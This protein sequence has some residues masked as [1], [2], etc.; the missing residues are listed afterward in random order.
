MG[1]ST[2]HDRL[3]YKERYV[4]ARS[5]P[6]ISVF[7]REYHDSP[8]GG[9]AGELKT[10]LR[11]AAEWHW[12][13]MHRQ[14]A[15]YVRECHICQKAKASNQS[16]TGLLQNLSILSHVWEHITMDFLE[17]LPL[18]EGADTM[19]VVIYRLTKFGHFI[20]LRHPYTTL[21]V[22]AMFVKEMVRLHG[23]PTSI[24]SDRDKVFISIFW[25]ELFQL[26]QTHLLRSTAYHPQT[27][28]QS[29]IE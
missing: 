11:L 22:A 24:V 3:F 21:K 2:D 15:N 9:H 29:E 13:G 7:L 10:Y 16:P 12:E 6:F 27:D 26:Q 1:F 4:L 25:Q 23:F 14:V 5:S 19:L 8:L 28:G 18:S 20:A 17:V